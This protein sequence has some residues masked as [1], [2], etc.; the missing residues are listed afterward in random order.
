[1]I[2]GV[3]IQRIDYQRYSR[4]VGEHLNYIIVGVHIQRID[5]QRYSR[6]VGEHFHYIIVGVH[7]QRI[8]YQLT[9]PWWTQ[10]TH[11]GGQAG[12]NLYAIIFNKCQFRV[13]QTYIQTYI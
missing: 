4:S 1:M 6:S 13:V 5:Y 10:S 2:V 12:K 3:H 9:T 7:T 11:V 8:D